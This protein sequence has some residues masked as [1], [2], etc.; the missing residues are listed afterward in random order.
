MKSTITVY[1]I[2][3]NASYSADREEWFK[4]R[5]FGLMYVTEQE[6]EKAAE[7]AFELTNAP[8]DYL[9]EQ[10]QE[11]LKALDF[12]GPSLSVGDIV[13]V[14]PIVRGSSLPEYYLCK[15]FGWEKF[16]GDRIALLKHLAD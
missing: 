10:H 15:S 4:D 14:E 13:R 2:P 6:G 9:S 16:E 11:L 1:R 5:S 7:E 8:Q 12:K 3:W